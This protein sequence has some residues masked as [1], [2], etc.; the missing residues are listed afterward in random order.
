MPNPLP[1]SVTPSYPIQTLIFIFIFF[2]RLSPSLLLFLLATVAPILSPCFRREFAGHSLV[3]AQQGGREAGGFARTCL[4]RLPPGP[5]RLTGLSLLA[6]SSSSELALFQKPSWEIWLRR[7]GS[8]KRAGPPC[9]GWPRSFSETPRDSPLLAQVETS[10][11]FPRHPT[12]RTR[13]HV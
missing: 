7:K 4:G 5:P 12:P 9:P 10:Q 6:F 2:E 13:S 3:G 11:P 8:G 1:R